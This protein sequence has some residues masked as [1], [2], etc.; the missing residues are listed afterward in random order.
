[1]P[2]RAALVILGLLAL[3][4]VLYSAGFGLRGLTADLSEDTRFFT[5]PLPNALIF[6]HMA[7]GALATCLAPLQLIERIRI[8]R[9]RAHRVLGYVTLGAATITGIC[10]LGYIALKG[11]IGGTLMSAGFALYGALLL[12]AA[13]NTAY[14]ALDKDRARHRRWALRLTV[15]ALGSFLYRLHYWVWYA[16]TGGAGSNAAFTGPFDLFNF[17]GFYLPYLAALELWLRQERR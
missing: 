7:T 12:L 10:G 6:T 8:R 16:A 9:P 13:A 4:F 14:H 11:T 5:T 15:L 3:P 1:M 2:R 17:A